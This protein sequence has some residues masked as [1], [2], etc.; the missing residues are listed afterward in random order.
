M[1]VLDTSGR[2]LKRLVLYDFLEDIAMIQAMLFLLRT[3]CKAQTRFIR[4]VILVKTATP[5]LRVQ[6]VD[7]WAIEPLPLYMKI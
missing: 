5:G 4:T 7:H 6:R 2:L 3:Q 1:Q